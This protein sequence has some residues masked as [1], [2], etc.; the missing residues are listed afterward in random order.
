MSKEL[1]WAGEL[2]D[3]A[4]LR[5]IHDDERLNNAL[6]QHF[7]GLVF[8]EGEEFFERDAKVLG[9]QFEG[10]NAWV[11]HSTLKPGQVAWVDFYEVGQRLLRH[12]ALLPKLFDSLAQF[13]SCVHH[14]LPLNA[15]V[16]SHRRNTADRAGNTH[17]TKES[18]RKM[19]PCCC[20]ADRIQQMAAKI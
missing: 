10:I 6:A 19:F 13:L 17:K 16:M 4:Q 8:G 14:A 20:L 11:M 1:G 3:T 12:T 2:G 5:L 9:Y 7:W 18:G 15:W